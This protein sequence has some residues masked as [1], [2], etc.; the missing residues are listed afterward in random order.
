MLCFHTFKEIEL[1]FGKHFTSLVFFPS[2]NLVQ[3]SVCCDQ[4]PKKGQV[5]Q[6]SHDTV[7]WWT[8]TS[9]C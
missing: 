1:G 4:R 2:K 6:L 3:C 5:A 9:L 7:R 8:N